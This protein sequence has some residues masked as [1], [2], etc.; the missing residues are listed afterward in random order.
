MT[1][2]SLKLDF[3]VVAKVTITPRPW[4]VVD[5]K[6]KPLEH[7]NN[8]LRLELVRIGLWCSHSQVLVV[9]VLCKEGIDDLLG[10]CRDD[11]GG[12]DLHKRSCCLLHIM[13][14][15][16]QRGNALIQSV[17][18]LGVILV[19]GDIVSVLDLTDLGGSLEVTF[20]CG[21]VFI[22]LCNLFGK[23][24]RIRF[25]FLNVSLKDLNHLI[26]LLDCTLLLNSGVIA[27]LL[28]CCELHLL[29]MLLLFA[30][31]DHAIQELN[32]FLH[33]CYSRRMGCPKA[34]EHK[35][36]LHHDDV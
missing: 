16:L 32:D 5:V 19:R 22:M 15:L 8:A 35:S 18:G 33:R 11:V 28:V 26:C 4:T 14:L 13:G 36:H 6:M 3:P 20:P 12:R 2:F 34:E 1:L 29:F 24:C 30:F 25:V 27:E 21:D 9:R 17:N 10:F 31:L 23:L 7:V